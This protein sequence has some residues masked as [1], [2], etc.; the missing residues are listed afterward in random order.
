MVEKKFGVDFHSMDGA[1]TLEPS[2]VTNTDAECGRFTKTHN[3]GW[4]ITANLCEDY[5]VWINSFEASHPKYGRICG[6]FEDIVYSDS[7]EGFQHFY[8]NHSPTAWDY[9]DI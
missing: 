9:G 3:S 2:E 1:L 8:K 7:E 6:D 4:T 5:F